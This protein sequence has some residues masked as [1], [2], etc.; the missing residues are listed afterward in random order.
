MRSR[1]STSWP[2]L[3]STAAS[4]GGG[5]YSLGVLTLNHCTVSGNAG[6]NGGGVGSAGSG[7]LE[8]NDSTVHSNAASNMGGGVYN[9]GSTATLTNSAIRVNTAGVSG[10]GVFN[11]TTLIMTSC[12]LTGNTATDTGGGVEN[13][14]AAT[15]TNCTL[16][17]NAAN[18]G[19]GGGVYNAQSGAVV[20]LV[21]CT[22]ADN[23]VPVS[24]GNGGGI[25]GDSATFHIKNT[26]IA[27]NSD[28]GGDNDCYDD[29]GMVYDY[30]GYNLMEYK[31]NCTISGDTT[32]S[33]EA[34]DPMLGP[35]TWDSGAWVHPLLGGSPA[36]DAIPGCNGGPPTDQRGVT[37]P[38]NTNCDMGAYEY[39]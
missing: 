34:I 30:Q 14:S 10:G 33:I 32:G 35:L 24:S 26:I 36:I 1:S 39:P 20:T 9:N 7:A 22:I 13:R 11:S 31:G 3:R 37:R 5:I 21:N 6:F 16:S 19:G 17:G 23:A 28:F 8:I 25:S 4:D 12:A 27:N 29:G 2:A 38:Q 15:L 18:G